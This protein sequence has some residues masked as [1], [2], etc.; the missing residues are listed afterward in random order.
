MTP[1]GAFGDEP[2]LVTIVGTNLG[3][4]SDIHSV[5]ICG[6]EQD[7]ITQ[8]STQVVIRTRSYAFDAT[9]DIATNSTQL[10]AAV[11]AEM[12]RFIMTYDPSCPGIGSRITLV[13]P[14]GGPR[15]GGNVLTVSGESLGSGTDISTVKLGNTA[16]S[17]VAQSDSAVTVVVKGPLVGAQ[18]VVVSSTCFGTAILENAYTFNLGA[19]TAFTFHFVSY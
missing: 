16:A 14:T 10:G 17:L 7:I 18:T 11:L 9:C 2:T 15:I 12:F 19:F 3:S 6:Q 4:G 5:Q 1:S 8:S 13:D